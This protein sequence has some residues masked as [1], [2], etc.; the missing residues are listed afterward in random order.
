VNAARLSAVRPVPFSVCELSRRQAGVLAAEWG[1][2]ADSV[3]RFG[4]RSFALYRRQEPLALLT[5]ANAREPEIDPRRGLYRS[6]CIELSGLH[7]APAPHAVGS[8]GVLARMWREHLALPGWPYYPQ[9]RKIALICYPA[10]A[11]ARRAVDPAE[12]W[13]PVGG[14]DAPG[15]LW[16]YWLRREP[17]G[18]PAATAALSASAPAR[19]GL[20]ELLA[21]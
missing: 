12:G 11:G 3:P 8:D 16:V 9:V 2:R 13:E 10:H 7:R 21:A 20:L 6:N 14:T 1:T 15:A 17:A 4:C 19:A 18:A 5:A